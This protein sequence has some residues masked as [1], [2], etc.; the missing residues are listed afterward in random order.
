ME[1][2]SALLLELYR[3]AHEVTFPRFEETA[4]DLVRPELRFDSAIWTAIALEPDGPVTTD[5]YFDNQTPEV[6]A[7][8]LAVMRGN[9]FGHAALANPG[10]T[11]NSSLDDPT[12][13]C[14]L[15]GPLDEYERRH[16]M[17]HALTTAVVDRPEALLRAIA[18]YRGPDAPRF[19]EG[20]RRLKHQLMPHLLEA[21][22]IHRIRYLE[23]GLEEHSR[24]GFSTAIA[25][26]EGRLLHADHSFA[27]QLC[28][29]FPG[30]RGPVLPAPVVAQLDAPTRVKTAGG[31]IVVTSHR[32]G[33]QYLIRVRN[34]SHVDMLTERELA[35]ASAFAKGRT[36]REIAGSLGLAPATIRN[37]ISH[38][39]AKLQVANKIELHAVLALLTLGL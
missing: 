14:D 34:R 4:L 17:V 6:I 13:N 2:F 15:R 36:Y 30:W 20:E 24:S 1:R 33:A 16:G 38:V 28:R 11:I 26:A 12:R 23:L 3:A 29:G 37:H 7:G 35:V 9:T 10:A 25:S 39:Y 32:V 21:L 22:T 5:V 27:A 18:L 8:Y 19:S 31:E